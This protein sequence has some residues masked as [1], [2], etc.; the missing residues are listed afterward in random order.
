MLLL[1]EDGGCP[2]LPAL[3]LDQT[4]SGGAAA[5]GKSLWTSDSRAEDDAGCHGLMPPDV[6][7]ANVE[8][9]ALLMLLVVVVV[10]W[11]VALVRGVGEEGPC[12]LLPLDGLALPPAGRVATETAATVL[13]GGGGN[14][15][16][17]GNAAAICSE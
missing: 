3:S 11:R 1:L 6:R 4:D 10:L 8:V 16:G 5:T 14:G 15:G 12:R 17:A 13:T 9:A 2:L 7:T